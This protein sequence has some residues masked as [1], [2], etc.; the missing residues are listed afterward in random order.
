[1]SF[2][3]EHKEN[4]ADS[5]DV[6]LSGI[7]EDSEEAE[8]KMLQEAGEQVKEYVIANLNKHRRVLAKR[9]YGR[10]AM[11]DDVKV[12]I[13]TNKQGFKVARVY[14]GKKTGTL[15]HLVNDGN[16]HSIGIHFM[17]GALARMDGTID[18]LWDEIMR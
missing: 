16:L 10:P 14:G 9:Y 5:F 11:A 6:F 4:D 18:K 1:M 8:K 15:W 7:L 2:K 12:S 3:I 17:D 13:V